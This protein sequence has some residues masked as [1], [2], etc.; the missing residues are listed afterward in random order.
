M[1]TLFVVATPIGNLGDL[2]PRSKETLQA[3]ALIAA[4]DTRHTGQM[5]SRV[6]IRVPM[7]SL[8]E[9][10][11]S[12][13]I[14]PVLN[15]LASGDVGLVSDAGTPTISDPGYQIVDAAHAAG[16]PVRTVP[17]P[18]GV[19]AALSVSGL[20]AVPF[21]FGGY[22]PRSAGEQERW[23]RAWLGR[24]ATFVCFESP[25]RVRKTVELLARIAPERQI[26][27]CRE[28]TKVHEQVVRSTTREA[29]ALIDA[30]EIAERGEF[31]LVI[32]ASEREANLD[33]ESLLRERLDAGDRPN[34]AA[35]TVAELTGLPKR[36]LYARAVEI[37]SEGQQS[38]RE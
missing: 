13:R 11:L 38:Q 30:G 28:L 21:T 14:T 24:P 2:S 17:G 22:A 26:S 32:G 23:F 33:P 19:V 36:E 10:N 34:V 5:L 29:L 37:R 3:C 9:H 16:Y 20:A 15:A 27:V 6:G 25:N 8:N 4:E 35:Q 1:G 18:S 7:I 12:Q 31:V